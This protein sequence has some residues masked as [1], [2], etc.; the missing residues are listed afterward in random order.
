MTSQQDS[1]VIFPG[2]RQHQI[3]LFC[4]RWLNK[5][6]WLLWETSTRP[7]SMRAHYTFAI[8]T[9]HLFGRRTTATSRHPPIT[10]HP[11]SLSAPVVLFVVRSPFVLYYP[12]PKISSF[13]SFDLCLSCIY[14]FSALR[15]T[16]K[17]SE[18][19]SSSP[20]VFVSVFRLIVFGLQ[21]YVLPYKPLFFPFACLVYSPFRVSLTVMDF[22]YFD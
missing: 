11:P 16:M 20:L 18:I 14:C 6:S 7:P 19:M 9:P 21:R 10:V 3:R 13:A 2:L 22:L 5:A 8:I 17:T 15:H 1:H 4:L 12:L